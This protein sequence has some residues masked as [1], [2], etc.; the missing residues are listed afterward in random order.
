MQSVVHALSSTRSEQQNVL[1]RTYPRF[2]WDSNLPFEKI[3]GAICGLRRLRVESLQTKSSAERLRVD[4]ETVQRDDLYATAFALQ[5]ALLCIY[6]TCFVGI[7]VARRVD[8]NA[9]R[10]VKESQRL[11]LGALP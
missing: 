6:Q 1:R 8:G 11:E 5:Q 3:H 7:Q 4:N 2:P 10:R 9:P